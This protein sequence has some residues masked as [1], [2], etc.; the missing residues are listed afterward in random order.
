MKKS[1]RWNNKRLSWILVEMDLELGLLE[2]I[3]I[4]MDHGSFIQVLDYL[5]EPFRCH[6][7]RHIGHIKTKSPFLVKEK[8]LSEA[9][10]VGSEK[11]LILPQKDYRPN[12]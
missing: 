9:V 3:E 1:L 10:E 12:L 7:C 6:F 8:V 4:L 2:D 5:R 11:G